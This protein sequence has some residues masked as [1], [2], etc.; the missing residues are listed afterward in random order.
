[1]IVYTNKHKI[2][3][4]IDDSDYEMVSQHSWYVNCRYLRTMFPES[5]V[6]G[7]YIERHSVFLHEFLM[8]RSP[9]KLLVWDHIDRNRMNNRRINLRLV[10]RSVSARNRGLMG[11]NTSGH[12]GIRI[13]RNGRFWAGIKAAPYVHVGLGTYD[14]LEEAIDARK[15]AEEL[16]WGNNK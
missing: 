15:K 8:G 7:V 6:N 3:F 9:D 12:V 1:M 2:P 4:E 10:D 11:H 13:R 5:F 16:Y 14:T